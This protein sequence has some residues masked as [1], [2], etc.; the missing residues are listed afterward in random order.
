MIGYIIGLNFGHSTDGLIVEVEGVQ[1]AAVQLL[2]PHTKIRCKA[3]R[4][5][6]VM[7][8][9]AG[10]AECKSDD[11]SRRSPQ[12][13]PKPG[14]GL[15]T[16]PRSNSGDEIGKLRRRSMIT[17]TATSMIGLGSRRSQLAGEAPVRSGREGGRGACEG[18]SRC[19]Q[20]DDSL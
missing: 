4:L 9:A 2:E 6:V 11:N 5:K 13:R 15:P 1:C 12:T 7:A 16:R 17:G 3:P 20:G 14:Q 10:A 18:M 19:G 8:A